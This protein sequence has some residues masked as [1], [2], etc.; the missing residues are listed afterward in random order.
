VYDKEDILEL[1]DSRAKGSSLDSS[2]FKLI[3]GSVSTLNNNLEQL[4]KQ[5]F[6]ITIFDEAHHIDAEGAKTFNNIFEIGKE[7]SNEVLGMSATPERTNGNNIIDLFGGE[8]AYTLSV[9]DALEKE[10][11]APF[12]YY[13][14]HSDDVIDFDFSK[15]S[16][17]NQLTKFMNT[18]E[19]FKLLTQAINSCINADENICCLIFCNSRETARYMS[20]R[21]NAISKKADYLVSESEKIKDRKKD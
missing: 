16:N 15:K 3:L 2:K 10:Y 7:I 18:E 4:Q 19:R 1:Y 14:L 17:E 20:D 5:E 11:L 13:M 9:Y 21:L 12:D 8:F 6:D